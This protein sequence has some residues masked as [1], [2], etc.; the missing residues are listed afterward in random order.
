M[1]PETERKSIADSKEIIWAIDRHFRLQIQHKP[2]E[3]QKKKKKASKYINPLCIAKLES[4]DRAMEQM[5]CLKTF[6]GNN[7]VNNQVTHGV[8][9]YLGKETRSV[10][11]LG[12][13]V[14][15]FPF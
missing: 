10:L 4:T 5:K 14:T 13:R 6:T 7:P 8:I 9:Q 11:R 3:K 1:I 15:I 2:K 12:L